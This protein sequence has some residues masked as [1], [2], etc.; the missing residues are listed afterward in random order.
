VISAVE[1]L[2]ACD[3]FMRDIVKIA[4]W[5]LCFSFLMNG[6]VREVVGGSGGGNWL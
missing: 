4:L 5:R 6:V 2:R 3:V 1:F